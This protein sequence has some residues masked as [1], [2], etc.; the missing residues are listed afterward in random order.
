MVHPLSFG[1]GNQGGEIEPLN[2]RIGLLKEVVV[3][4]DVYVPVAHGPLDHPHLLLNLTQHF[5][6]GT[7]PPSTEVIK[8]CILG[9][10][11]P[12]LV[13]ETDIELELSS[14]EELFEWFQAQNNC[15]GDVR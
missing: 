5:D 3:Q 13:G 1:E 2:L 14:I 11:L 7:G 12:R 10:S 6:V 15:R 8:K 9:P 4:N